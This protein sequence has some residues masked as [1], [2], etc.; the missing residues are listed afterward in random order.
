MSITDQISVIS[1]QKL[2]PTLLNPMDL[3]H[4][5]AKIEDQQ[6]SHPHLALPQWRGE[7]IWYMY[8]FM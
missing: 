5:L 2:K 1:S 6:M 4:V 8:K 7:Y 3:K